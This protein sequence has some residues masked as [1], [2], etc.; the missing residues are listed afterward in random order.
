MRR[1]GWLVGAAVLLSACSE[2]SV[3]TRGATP[4]GAGGAP[5]T[6]TSEVPPTTVPVTPTTPAPSTSAPPTTVG[7]GGDVA[8]VAGP[9]Y[10]VGWWNGAAWQ[11]GDPTT[12]PPVADGTDVQVLRV[13]AAPTSAVA[14]PVELDICGWALD[15]QPPPGGS[16]PDA[17]PVVVA[18]ARPLLPRPSAVVEPTPEDVAAAAEVLARRGLPVDA[19]RVKRV[20][21][22]DIDGDRVDERIVV[23]EDGYGTDAAALAPSAPAGSYSLV[24][25]RTQL[26]GSS[27]DAILFASV[28]PVEQ[29]GVLAEIADVAAVADLN[30]DGRMEVVVWSAYYEGSGMTVF[31]YQGDDLGP[32]P[33]LA[34]GCGV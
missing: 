23:A 16:F 2:S 1:A 25:M 26:D 34:G 12:V 5:S 9:G 32:V 17:D 28:H 4:I 18:A 31:E 6:A 11:R 13:G 20:V 24:M 7:D 14:S 3:T 21:V 33:V 10:V 8:V 30:D 29:E 22:A 19:P 15:V 27:R